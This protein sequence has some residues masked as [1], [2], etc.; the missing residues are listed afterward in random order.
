MQAYKMIAFIKLDNYWASYLPYAFIHMG[1]HLKKN[2]IEYK[3]L[4]NT[5]TSEFES[6]KEF[7]LK[8][9]SILKPK[10]VAFSVI[11]GRQAKDSAEF[12][13]EIKNNFSDIKILWGGYHPTILPEQCITQKY[14]DYVIQ[15]EADQTICDFYE[16]LINDGNLDNIPGCWW[17]E[18]DMIFHSNGPLPKADPKDIGFDFSRI[19]LSKY[20]GQDNVLSLITS[21]GCPFNCQFCINQSLDNKKWRPLSLDLI[22]DTIDFFRANNVQGL[23]INDDNFY[24]KFDRAV[25]ILEHANMPS[26]S[27]IR[28]PTL[29]KDNRIKTLRDLKCKKLM[30]GAESCDN[31]ILEKIQ[32]GQTYEQMV[33]A[34]EL[35]GEHKEIQ[36]SWSFI[37]GMPVESL[38]NVINTINGKQALE[39]IA[40]RNIGPIGI[41]TPYPGSPM[42]QEALRKGFREKKDP[43]EWGIFERYGF[44]GREFPPDHEE[45]P[46]INIKEVWHL[47]LKGYKEK[48]AKENIPLSL[49]DR[50]RNY[51]SEKN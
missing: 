18:E 7:F 44:N 41:Y 9:L 46:W 29:L 34:A 23:H 31:G 51:F 14:I 42:Y 10:I 3:V 21:R 38:Q 2:N 24:V 5:H 19:K 49:K 37:I 35:F 1:Y 16:V 20:I 25:E 43:L 4:H 48:N 15:G 6:D 11:T 30:S 27:E 13:I 26:F 32:K 22:K 8:R 40:G 39:K 28:I 45:Y 12:S 36:P 50:I 47:A 17:K 33:H